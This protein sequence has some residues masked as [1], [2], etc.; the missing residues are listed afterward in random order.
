MNAKIRPTP[1]TSTAVPMIAASSA[2][3][4]EVVM[5]SSRL[6]FD[7]AIEALAATSVAGKL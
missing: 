3:L 4:D 5:C 2:D 1:T 6:D 7:H